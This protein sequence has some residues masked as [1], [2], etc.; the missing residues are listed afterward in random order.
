MKTI[1][2][3]KL[4]NTKAALYSADSL[5]KLA[6]CISIFGIIEENKNL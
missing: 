1:N 3:N 6:I 2:L 4:K 5:G